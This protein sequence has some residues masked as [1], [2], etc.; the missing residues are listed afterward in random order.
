MVEVDGVGLEY[1]GV[2]GCGGVYVFV[3]L[4]GIERCVVVVANGEGNDVVG[5][6]LKAPSSTH[7]MLR[8]GRLGGHVEM[9]ASSSDVAAKGP[10]AAAPSAR[11][12]GVGVVVAIVGGRH[13]FV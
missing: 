12:G 13:F 1:V 3:D 10:A 6:G 5:W 4:A 7:Q 9:K 11:R 2:V 8:K